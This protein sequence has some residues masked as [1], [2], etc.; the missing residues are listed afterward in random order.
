M[1]RLV[2]NYLSPLESNVTLIVK[3]GYRDFK[4]LINNFVDSNVYQVAFMYT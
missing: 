2:F 1:L 4:I 3:Y